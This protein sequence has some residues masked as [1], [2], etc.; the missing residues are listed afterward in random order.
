M[1]FES[2]WAITVACIMPTMFYS[3]RPKDDLDLLPYDPK[4]IGFFLSSPVGTPGFKSR[5]RPPCPQRVVKG[6]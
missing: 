2:E 6:D 4:S 5:I 3:E 1:K